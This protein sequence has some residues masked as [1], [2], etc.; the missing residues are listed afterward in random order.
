[1]SYGG[2]RVKLKNIYFFL[3][4]IWRSDEWYLTVF[5]PIYCRG[6][7]YVFYTLQEARPYSFTRPT[8]FK[9]FEIL[10]KRIKFDVASQEIAVAPKI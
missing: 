1:M 8:I 7:N 2:G 6:S 9:Q 4:S 10:P 5:G 3:A